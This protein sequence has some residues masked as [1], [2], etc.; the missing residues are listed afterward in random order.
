MS[1]AAIADAALDAG[2]ARREAASVTGG[3]RS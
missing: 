3:A 1:G 2:Q